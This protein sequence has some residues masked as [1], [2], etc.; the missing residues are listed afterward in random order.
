MESV[1]TR[2]VNRGAV[3]IL[4]HCSDLMRCAAVEPPDLGS[5]VL[6][7]PAVELRQ[8]GEVGYP[9]AVGAAAVIT[10]K[11]NC[12]AVGNRGKQTADNR[13]LHPYCRI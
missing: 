1:I 8:N 5:H 10:R 7:Y 2:M 6:L 3:E 4:R 12:E 11:M 9:Q 13:N